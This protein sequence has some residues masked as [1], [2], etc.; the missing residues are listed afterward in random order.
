MSA[1]ALFAQ[2]EKDSIFFSRP[3]GHLLPPPGGSNEPSPS[4]LYSEYD[5][6]ADILN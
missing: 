6:D 3:Y 2:F 5:P 1:N 4:E